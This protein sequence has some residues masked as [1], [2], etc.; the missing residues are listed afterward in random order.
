MNN[1]TAALL[2]AQQHLKDAQQRVRELEIELEDSGE[3]YAVE[4]T[5]L[6]RRRREVFECMDIAANFWKDIS[7]VFCPT[8]HKVFV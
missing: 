1:K 4:W 5:E 2:L 8:L 3:K 6:G 7:A